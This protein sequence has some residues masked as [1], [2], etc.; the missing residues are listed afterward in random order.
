MTQ[1]ELGNRLPASWAAAEAMSRLLARAGV[2]FGAEAGEY[3]GGVGTG[4]HR[5]ADLSED[6]FDRRGRRSTRSPS[7]CQTTEQPNARPSSPPS[8]AHDLDHP[9]RRNR[10][11]LRC[12]PTGRRLGPAHPHRRTP[13]P[14]QRNPRAAPTHSNV[15]GLFCVVGQSPSGVS[16]LAHP[17]GSSSTA[18]VPLAFGDASLPPRT[19]PCCARTPED[20]EGSHAR[21]GGR[22]GRRKERWRIA[23]TRTGCSLSAS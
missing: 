21:L 4:A 20:G 3:L 12:R 11:R 17:P 19:A 10:P 8:A 6:L 7:T 23:A 2:V 15:S 16:R 18:A 9:P 5:D 13:R 14:T 1:T 22:S